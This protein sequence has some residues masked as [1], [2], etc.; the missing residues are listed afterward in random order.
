MHSFSCKSSPD[1]NII[2]TCESSIII[3]KHL[4]MYFICKFYSITGMCSITIIIIIIVNNNRDTP[5][6]HSFSSPQFAECLTE[7]L[8]TESGIGVH[9]YNLF[10]GKSTA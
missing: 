9:S 6:S 7:H 3:V 10:P 4:Y 5:S 8:V 2:I 1:S